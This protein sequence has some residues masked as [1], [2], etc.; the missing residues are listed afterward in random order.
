MQRRFLPQLL[1]GLAGVLC[2]AI[3]SPKEISSSEDW[4]VTSQSGGVTIYSRPHAGSKL[5]DFKAIGQ[6]DASSG[7]VHGV[8]ADFEA[9]PSFMPY[10]A[11]CRLVKR[12]NDSIITYQRLSPKIL[13]DRDY[14]LRVRWT[15]RPGDGGQVYSNTWEPA[16]ELGPSEKPG[17]LRVKICEGSWLL[18]P[19]GP[20][21]TR[22]TYSIYTDSGGAIP[23][24]L[25]NKV[26]VIGIGK[27]FAAVRK[28]ATNPKHSVPES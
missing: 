25:A 5:K 6:I 21:R 12:E 13:H 3:D 1:F 10:T 14:T 8:I 2:L 24:F 16:N 19:D 15:S 26:S 27:L 20:N 11:E 7:I 9:Y 28:Q 23:S 17:V 18:E 22:A 4:K